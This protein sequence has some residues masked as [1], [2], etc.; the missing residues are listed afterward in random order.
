LIRVA[1]DTSAAL[2]GLRKAIP[3]LQARLGP[4]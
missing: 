2:A 1:R 3:L 4:S